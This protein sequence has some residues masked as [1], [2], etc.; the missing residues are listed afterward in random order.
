M[1]RVGLDGGLLRFVV[2][3]RA[4]VCL[5]VAS[6]CARA[7]VNFN[8]LLTDTKQDVRR[9]RGA[10]KGWGCSEVPVIHTTDNTTDNV[11]HKCQK[12]APPP[13]NT[14][15]TSAEAE[16]ECMN[17]RALFR[18]RCIR[19]QHNTRATH[20]H[21]R[22][23]GQRVGVIRRHVC[24]ATSAVCVCAHFLATTHVRPST[25]YPDNCES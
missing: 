7:G 5:C 24:W 19:V 12:R 4:S 8:A 16:S 20:D 10:P 18:Q 21:G 23:C 17:Q 1:C 25:T 11:V 2:M 22:S 13:S 6:C 9:E 3:L 14:H 15:H